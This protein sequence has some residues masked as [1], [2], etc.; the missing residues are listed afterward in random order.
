MLSYS[1]AGLNM[2]PSPTTV[3]GDIECSQDANTT[4]LKFR[5]AFN[6]GIYGHVCSTTHQQSRKMKVE[7]KRKN[8]EKGGKREKG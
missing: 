3:V 8:G 7:A 6:N 2:A 4:T 1:A 5:R